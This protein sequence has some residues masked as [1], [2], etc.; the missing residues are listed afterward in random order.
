MTSEVEDF[1]MKHRPKS[2]L[3][4]YRENWIPGSGRIRDPKAGRIRS[5]SGGKSCA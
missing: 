1:R 3:Y 5:Y 2:I 4:I